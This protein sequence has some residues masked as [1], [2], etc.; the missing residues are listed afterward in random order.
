MKEVDVAARLVLKIENFFA[1]FLRNCDRIVR[2][3]SG[4]WK[5]SSKI[6]IRCAGMAIAGFHAQEVP[7]M[8]GE[9]PPGK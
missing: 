5:K 6:V 8:K 7:S 9:T 4:Q 3:F 1:C 2:N